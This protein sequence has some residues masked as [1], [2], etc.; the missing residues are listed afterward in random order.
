[1]ISLLSAGDQDILRDAVR[2][3]SIFWHRVR[4]ATLRVAIVA[5]LTLLLLFT[6]VL[7]ILQPSIAGLAWL[8]RE[9]LGVVVSILSVIW[10]VYTGWTIFKLMPSRN[11]R[12]VIGLRGWVRGNVEPLEA[13]VQG[14]TEDQLREKTAEF[15][16]RL[17]GGE[18]LASIRPEA[19]ACVREAS[20]RARA[21]R[22]FECQLIG[23]KVL[24]ECNV[25]EMRPA[26]GKTIVCY[27]ANYLKVL[28][29]LHVHM[30]TVN[31]YLV[32]RDAEFCR[33]IFELLGVT[34]GHISSEMATYGPEAQDRKDA[35]ACN[36]T[37][38]TN[39]GIW[40]RLPAR[41]YEDAR[42]GPGAGPAGLH[43]CRRGGLDSDR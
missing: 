37:Y 12:V 32:K 23:G 8:T 2:A 24:E 26:E 9:A 21:H 27:M 4:R 11:D 31:D 18:P 7:L 34:V 43:R 40:L 16:R 42:R 19:Y 39:S 36:I 13:D 6:I 28:E 29:G 1:M 38:G 22:Q 14:L 25:A 20:K 35:Y 10:L 30:V 15:K 17:E 3:S 5:G 33:P 41:Q